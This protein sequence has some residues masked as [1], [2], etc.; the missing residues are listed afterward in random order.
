M[1]RTSSAWWGAAG[2][3][4]LEPH[5]TTAFSSG[6][7]RR[8]DLRGGGGGRRARRSETKSIR[9]VSVSCP[10]AEIR[11]MAPGGDGRAPAPR[12]VKGHRSFHR[13]APPRATISKV[14]TGQG[15]AVVD[16]DRSRGLPPPPAPLQS[17]PCTTTGQTITCAG[18][19]SAMRCRMSRITAP[20]GAGDH[21]DHRF[22]MAGK[23]LFALRRRTDLP[24]C[25]FDFSFSSWAKSAP[26]PRGAP[27]S[28]SPSD[29]RSGPDRW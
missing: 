18:Q 28:R 3:A 20:G 14:R 12:R 17:A 27:W 21:A 16:S 29:R 7:H 2:H 25:S 11:G 26:T 5:S 23:G 1:R 15:M 9:V 13:A 4:L 10:T 19:R 22:G 24:P 6:Q 8:G